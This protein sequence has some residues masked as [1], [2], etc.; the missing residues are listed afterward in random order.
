MSKQSLSPTAID[1]S[2]DVRRKSVHELN[3]CLANLF[4]LFGQV[5][6]AHWNVRGLHFI[7]FHKLFDD[8]AEELEGSIDNIAERATQLGGV[9]MG[10]VRMAAVSSKVAEIP[11]TDLSGEGLL[12]GL[13]TS[14]ATVTNHA[15]EAI[16]VCAELEDDNTSDLFTEVSR[17]LD[18]GLWFLEAHLRGN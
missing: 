13:I 8:L 16:K 4:D 5:S 18:K 7:A 1:L 9:A 15:R 6:F 17:E 14:Y 3:Q 2:E 10:T 11:T 12:K